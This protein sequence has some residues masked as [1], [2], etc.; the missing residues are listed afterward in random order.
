[1]T[2]IRIFVDYSKRPL[3]QVED[4]PVGR[5]TLAL[6]HLGDVVVTWGDEDLGERKA[7]V[8]GVSDEPGA[9]AS[10]RLRFLEALQN[11]A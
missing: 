9:P 1:M 3:R 8:V 10:V 7:R 2:A 5:G 11:S 4:V 6:I